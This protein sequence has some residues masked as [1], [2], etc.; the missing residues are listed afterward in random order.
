MPIAAPPMQHERTIANRELYDLSGSGIA[1]H[2]IDHV[3]RARDDL[4]GKQPPVAN[5][6]RK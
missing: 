6:Q 1:H 2:D 3:M 5:R 4:R